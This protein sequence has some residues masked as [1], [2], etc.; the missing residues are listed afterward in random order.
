[1]SDNESAIVDFTGLV[2]NV[3]YGSIILQFVIRLEIFIFLNLNNYL[4]K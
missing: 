1:M 4:S 2:E 3:K